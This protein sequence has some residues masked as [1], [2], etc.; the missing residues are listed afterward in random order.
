M[1]IHEQPALTHPAFN[2]PSVAPRSR[3]YAHGC[4]QHL[5]R[6]TNASGTSVYVHRPA[7]THPT[8]RTRRQPTNVMVES[9][10]KIT[11]ARSDRILKIPLGA[12]SQT[13][14]LY[15]AKY[16]TTSGSLLTAA[17]IA[18]SLGKPSMYLMRE[19]ISCH[20]GGHQGG[21]QRDK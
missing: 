10:R 17:C 16:A 5:R 6:S 3:L 20:H 14:F 12:L 4:V 1:R 15:S 8:L 18:S 9:S 19:A 7:F 21:H 11:C 13:Q 2:A